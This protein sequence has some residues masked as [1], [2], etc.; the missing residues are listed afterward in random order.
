LPACRAS[1]A[2]PARARPSTAD[3]PT[4]IFNTAYFETLELSRVIWTPPHCA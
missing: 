2:L 4:L 1:I 3:S